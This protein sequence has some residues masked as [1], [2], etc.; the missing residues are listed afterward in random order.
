MIS[1]DHEMLISLLGKRIDKLEAKMAKLEAKPDIN[2]QDWDNQTLM[3]QWTCSLRSTANFRKQGLEYYK[4][5]G[6]VFYTPEAREKFKKQ[7]K[8]QSFNG[9]RTKS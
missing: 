2:N 6:R 5:G 7:S 9:G 4:R 8:P 3:D 1:Q